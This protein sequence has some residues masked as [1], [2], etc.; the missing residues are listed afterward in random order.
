MRITDKRFAGR[1]SA[2]EYKSVAAFAT[3]LSDDEREEF[4][5][6]ELQTLCVV[7]RA[8]A[9]TVRAALESYGF[10]LGTRVP[11]RAVRGFTA[12]CHNRWDGAQ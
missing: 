4:T 8:S 2:P 10:R 3:W 12:N 7:L 11:F 1:L 5:H 6:E 9:P